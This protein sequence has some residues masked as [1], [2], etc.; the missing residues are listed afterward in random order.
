MSNRIE[1]RAFQP[2]LWQSLPGMVLVLSTQGE[3][4]YVSPDYRELAGL[5]HGDG[6]ISDWTATLKPDAKAALQAAL[7]QGQ[8]FTLQFE[9][10]TGSARP[11]W[12]DLAAHR[13]GGLGYF[14]CLVHDVSAAHCA[15]LAARV[16]AERLRLLA[17]NMPA[18]I[19][20]YSGATF[21]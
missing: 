14:V 9:L 15:D 7:A 17:D 6:Q 13:L 2:A 16:S 18:L 20:Y 1:Q 10:D 5:A 4:L 11:G 21:C 12:V 19:A 8:D 3:A